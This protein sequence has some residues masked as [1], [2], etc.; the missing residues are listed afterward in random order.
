MPGRPGREKG[1]DVTSIETDRA[2]SAPTGNGQ[3]ARRP[4][5]A[6]V[7]VA[8]APKLRRRP[9]LTAASVGAVCLG[10]LVSVWAWSATNNTHDV[11]AVRDTVHRG[12]LI[13]A[14]DLMTVRV[15]SDPA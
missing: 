9:L 13:G 8:P 1:R 4:A 7:P 12:E 10:A 6:A 2:R 15:G 14:G 11:L 3:G 5:E